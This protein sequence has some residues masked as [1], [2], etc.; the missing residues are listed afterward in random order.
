MQ[1]CNNQQLYH[2]TTI[3]NDSSNLYKRF[4]KQFFINKIYC[5]A[6]KQKK[7]K[8]KITLHINFKFQN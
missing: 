5:V 4:I 6:V 8:F 2:Q 1:K 7:I 3:I